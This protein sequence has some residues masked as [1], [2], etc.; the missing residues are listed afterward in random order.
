[1]PKVATRGA[2]IGICNICGCNSQLTEDHIPP[3]GLLKPTQVEMLHLCES[4]KLEKFKK[5]HRLSQNGL[6]FRTLCANCNNNLLGSQNDPSLIA[7]A[8]EAK[9]LLKSRIYL[10]DSISVEV[11]PNRLCRSVV[12]HLLAAQLDGHRIGTTVNSL[13]DYFLQ[14]TANLPCDIEIYYWLYP[15]SDQ[16]IVPGAGW[17]RDL[18]SS[19]A[20]ISVIKFFPLAF[21]IISDKPPDWHFRFPSLRPYLST[22]IDAVLNMPIDLVNIPPQRWPEL[23]G[24]NDAL[25]HSETAI[26][27]KLQSKNVLLA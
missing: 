7:F 2:P 5:P 15:Y 12:G 20:V 1:M 9:S 14:P 19:F 8:N 26:R 13:T 23:P 18:G 22:N 10:P 6:K 21:L 27:A 11:K 25:M 4:L 3:K 24:S 17:I 16:V